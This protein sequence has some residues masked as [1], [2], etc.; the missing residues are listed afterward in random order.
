MMRDVIGLKKSDK[1]PIYLRIIDVFSFIYIRLGI[2]YPQMRSILSMKMTVD[3]RKDAPLPGMETGKRSE[4]EKNHFFSS[5]WVYTLISVFLLV[6]FAYDN[7][8]F[9]YTLYFSFLFIMTFSTLIANFSGILLDTKDGTLIGT[10]PVDRKTLG[11][12]KSTHVGIYLVAFTLAIGLPVILFTFYFNGIVAGLL[13]LFLSFLA[14]LWCLILTQFVYAT[15]LKRFDGERL[16]NIIAYSQISLSIFMV[17]GYYLVGQIFQIIDP[18][19][20]LV[21]INLSIGHVLLFPL[22]FVAPFGML[23]E[24]W[25]TTYGLYSFLLIA[26]TVFLALIYNWN[27]DRI[28]SNLQKMDASSVQQSRRGYIERASARLLCFTPLESAYY[29]FGWQLTK[30][31]RE[32]KTRLYPSIASALVFPIV[33]TFN[34]LTGGQPGM[35]TSPVQFLYLPYFTL[36]L[37]PVLAVSIQFSNHYKGSWVFSITPGRSRAP[38]LRAVTK[39][40]LVK[41]LLPMYS[42]LAIMVLFFTDLSYSLQMINGLLLVSL[43]LYFETKRSV[44]VM[45]FTRKY[46]ASDANLGCMGTVIFLVP[47]ILVSI[48]MIASQLFIPFAEWGLLFLLTGLNIWWMRSGF[49]RKEDKARAK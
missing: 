31:E 32:F 47:V 20:L 25:S 7:W 26:G 27:S 37:V 28:E 39:A 10:K 45:P 34:N 15:I 23:Q 1:D 48:V 8:V 29:H 40:M 16:K 13:V 14:S 4:E 19:N 9:Q 42:I 5:L 24:G 22:W 3:G 18:E 46:S 38:F 41:I 2:N 12:A 11:A 6:L 17:I 43:I 21:E 36:F 33:M 44:K 49:E 30:T 35:E